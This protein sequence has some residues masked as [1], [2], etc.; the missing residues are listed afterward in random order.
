MDL[1]LAIV[2]FCITYF[3]IILEKSPITYSALIGGFSMVLFNILSTNAAYQ[4]IEFEVIFLLIGMM[5]IVEVFSITGFFEW[6][7]IKIAQVVKG[8][9]LLL[10]FFLS[11]ITA[12][13][14]AFLANI[15]VILLIVPI[16]L[17]LTEVLQLNPIPYILSEI[18]ASNI[19]G[20]STYIGDPPNIIIGVASQ[21]SFND[22]IINLFP[23]NALI[24]HCN[25]SYSL[26]I[27]S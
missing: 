8:N 2:I 7:A 26:A 22:F 16:T 9:P 18:F 21:L 20:A 19:G 11:L 13:L 10:L 5:I 1:Y 17:L 14:S 27:F 4:S 25:N 3:F 12:V 24:F 6:S 23:I 15:T